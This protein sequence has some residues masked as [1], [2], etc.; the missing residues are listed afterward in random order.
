M[1]HYPLIK[2]KR[3]LAECEKEKNGEP[4]AKKREID[5]DVD[6]EDPMKM[7]MSPHEG[8]TQSDTRH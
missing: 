7:K 8:A 3:P 4:P 6:D 5:A 2:P 1:N